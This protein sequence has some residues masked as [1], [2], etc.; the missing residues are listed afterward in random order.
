MTILLLDNYDSFT[1]NLYDYLRQAG[2]TCIVLRNDAP[3]LLAFSSDDFDAV[4]L[5]PGPG[6]PEEAGLMLDLL[7]AWHQ[8]LPIL[9]V[10]LGHQAIGAFWG[11]SVGRAPKPMHGKTSIV[12]HTGHPLFA[13]IPRRFRVMRYHSLA[14]TGWENTPLRPLAW[15]DDG[16]LMAMVHR[17][18]PIAGVQFHPESALT[19]HGLTFIR[20]WVR[21]AQQK[22]A[23]RRHR[24]ALFSR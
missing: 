9:G 15:A 24:P 14:V 12:W 2:T 16:V 6:R 3:D 11:A 17:S 18:L 20:N 19:E 21:W 7:A 5:S 4:V 10:C 23:I 8:H 1:Y 22:L 13:H